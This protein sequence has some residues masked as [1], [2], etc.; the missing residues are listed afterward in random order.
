MDDNRLPNRPKKRRIARKQTSIMT[1][2]PYQGQRIR[3]QEPI[4]HSIGQLADELEVKAYAVGGYVRDYYLNRPRTDLD[5][6][7]I[8]DALDFA[9]KFAEKMSSKAVVFERFRTAMVPVSHFQCEFVGTRKEEYK[10]GSRKPIVTEGTLNDDL[11]RR[12]FTINAMAVSLNNDTMGNIIDL[13]NGKRDIEQKKL[14]TP[15]EPKTTFDDDPLRM[16]RAARFASQLGFEIDEKAYNAA[17]QMAERIEIV[18]QER[19]SDEFL[20]IINSPKPSIGLRFL[21]NTGILKI[22][23][24]E[25][26]ELAGVDIIEEEDK[27]YKHKDVFFHSLKVLEKVAEKSDNTWLR[28]AALLHD[29]GKPVT[30]KFVESIGWT[31]HGHEEIGARKIMKIFKRMKFP[32]ENV[33]YVEKLIRL[34]QRP[35]TLVDDGVTDSAIRRL[36]VSADDALDDLFTLVRADITTKNP[37]LSMK[38]LNN[39]ERVRS[40]VIRVQ[41][42]DK[43]REFQS[44]VRGDEIMDIC[45]LEPSK[46]VGLIKSAIEEAIL[47]GIIPNDYNYALDYFLKNKDNWLKE[48]SK[49]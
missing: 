46:T 39:Y 36:A 1:V 38:Y 35:M 33:D 42:K 29:I 47:D 13:F 6:T 21:Y 5:I 41:E 9:E 19:T 4:L 7:I 8:G 16:M 27:T 34:H 32:L 12:D 30:K 20:K 37:N 48:F 15:L 43:L 17:T 40:K 45:K 31:F 18:S 11:K 25:L 26:N 44:P 28:I 10:K 22:I 23:F 49:N 24:P 3:I 14:I 2:T